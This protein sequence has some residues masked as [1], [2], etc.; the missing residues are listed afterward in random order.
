MWKQSDGE[1]VTDTCDGT[2][3]NFVT[4]LNVLFAFSSITLQHLNGAFDTP[5]ISSSRGGFMLQ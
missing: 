5:L 2:I 3:V 4:I 1:E